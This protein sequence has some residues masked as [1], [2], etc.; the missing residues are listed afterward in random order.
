MKHRK[1]LLS[2]KPL[3]VEPFE[4]GRQIEAAAK[5]YRQRF[6]ETNSAKDNTAKDNTAM[7]D[8]E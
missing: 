2:A 3:R 1:P 7:G 6:G 5:I 4:Y 8:Y